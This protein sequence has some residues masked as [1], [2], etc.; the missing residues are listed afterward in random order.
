MWDVTQK[1]YISPTEQWI[2]LLLHR[3]QW[4]HN[5]CDGVS[6]HQC[7]DCSD[8]HQRKHKSSPSLAFVTGIHRW[9]ADSPH[10]G[11]VT[12]G[13]RHRACN[14]WK[15]LGEMYVKYKTRNGKMWWSTDCSQLYPPKC[16][17]M[18]M[19][20]LRT[21]Y[22]YCHI[23]DIRNLRSIRGWIHVAVLMGHVICFPGVWPS[24]CC[25]HIGPSGGHM[26]NGI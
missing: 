12:I 17:H 23:R 22:Y 19:N 16:V 14:Y 8:T 18:Y 15:D 9:P 3:L 25:V 1:Y 2:S 20:D 6:S 11:S 4:R 5:E 21:H 10:K 26:W 24:H 7:P 13:L